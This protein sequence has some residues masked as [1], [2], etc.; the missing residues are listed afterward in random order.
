METYEVK[1]E[2]VVEGDLFG[3]RVRSE[4]SPGKHIPKNE[5]QE[6]ALERL[7]ALGYATRVKKS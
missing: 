7:V 1:G 5:A 2:Y 3:E 4:F 6:E